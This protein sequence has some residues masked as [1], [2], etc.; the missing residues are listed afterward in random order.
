MYIGISTSTTS[1]PSD[2]LLV[3]FVLLLS[4]PPFSTFSWFRLRIT[5]DDWLADRKLLRVFMELWF[6]VIK[7]LGPSPTYSMTWQ[8]VTCF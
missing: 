2:E 3:D 5:S 4:S 8:N 7:I 6:L 1:P